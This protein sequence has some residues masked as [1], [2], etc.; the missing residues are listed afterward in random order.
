MAK[1][2]AIAGHPVDGFTFYGPFDSSE[3]ASSWAYDRLH[4][5]DFWITE[6]FDVTSK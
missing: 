1:Y 6:L 3:E 4:D 2:I 5:E